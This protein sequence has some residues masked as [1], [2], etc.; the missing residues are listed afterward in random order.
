[1]KYQLGDH[2]GS[3]HVVLDDSGNLINREEYTPYG[4]TSFGSFVRKRY[5]FTGKERDEESGLYYHG[6][7][8]YAPWLG[9]WAS[10]DHAGSRS[11]DGELLYTYSR[12]DPLRFADLT[13]MEAQDA[14][15][16]ITSRE[17]VTNQGQTIRYTVQVEASQIK[18][19]SSRGGREDPLT[20]WL[21]SSSPKPLWGQTPNDPERSQSIAGTQL[22]RVDLLRT[23]EL[24]EAERLLGTETAATRFQ[25]GLGGRYT[26]GT[27]GKGNILLPLRGGSRVDIDWLNT[28]L[29]FEALGVRGEGPI[30]FL[31]MA[32]KSAWTVADT[33]TSWFHQRAAKQ[34]G[35]ESF[36]QAASQSFETFKGH[37][38]AFAS[39]EE[40]I[41]AGLAGSFYTRRWHFRDVLHPDL[42]RE[43]EK[44]LKEVRLTDL[45]KTPSQL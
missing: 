37:L 13:G 24:L 3:S 44:T 21:Q 35:L 1:M 26:W 17:V 34:S 8:Y 18:I 27:T 2:L 10:T 31:Y 14:T 7:R 12:N 30:T 43:A 22:T 4:E 19:H 39:A 29:S 5:R 28:L 9:R 32:G 11:R 40:A 25:P 42:V 23:G 36:R 16:I 20:I 38:E 33:V 6:A 15:N 41:A 45:Q